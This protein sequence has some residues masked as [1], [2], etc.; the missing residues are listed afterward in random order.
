V[1]HLEQADC[2]IKR[3]HRG[4]E[5]C[6]AEPDEAGRADLDAPTDGGTLTAGGT[7]DDGHGHRVVGEEVDQLGR[8]VTA[9]VVDHDDPAA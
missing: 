5:V 4:G 2:I 9:A 6:V 7:P 1:P 3:L 8:A